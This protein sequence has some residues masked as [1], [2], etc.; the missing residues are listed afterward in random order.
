MN[1]KTRVAL[2]IIFLLTIVTDSF[3]QQIYQ[4][5][6]FDKMQG[7]P[8]Q[9]AT[10][11][12]I[13]KSNRKMLG[14]AHS[15]GMG[16]LQ[17][18]ADTLADSILVWVF[19]KKYVD[20]SS[21]IDYNKL[22]RYRDTIE[23]IPLSKVLQTVIVTGNKAIT[24]NG[25]TVSYVAD[26]FKLPAGSSAEDLLKKLPGIQVAKDGTIKAQGKKVEKVLVDGDDFFGEDA[27]VATKN[28]EASMIDK[29]EVIDAATRKS[30]ATGSDDEKMKI[31]NLKL[32]D[33]AKRG[34]FGK[35]EGG[36]S[37]TKRYNGTAMANVFH[38]NTKVAGFL[39]ADNMRSRM[40]WEDMRDLGIDNQSW[41]YDEDLDVWVNKGGDAS[42]GNTLEVIPN[43]L[44]TG[45]ILNQKF[46]DG[47][48]TLKMRY[49][50]N[51]SRYDGHQ[52]SKGT[53]FYGDK[54]QESENDN[55]INSQNL[56]NSGLL[57][58]DKT[59]D[60]QQKIHVGFTANISQYEGYN[61]T[62]QTILLDSVL[63]NRSQRTNPFDNKNEQYNVIGEY[64]KKF[65]KKGRFMGLKADYSASVLNGN[66]Y[67]Q[68]QGWLYNTIGD[69]TV[70]ALDQKTTTLNKN[71]NLKLSANF[72]EPIF[73]KG[74]YAEL[75]A[76]MA[77]ARN[78]S[79]YNTFAKNT[80]NNE[81]NLSLNSLSNNYYYNVNAFSEHI[82]LNF[83]SKKIEWYIGSK[84]HQVGMEQ[85]NIDTGKASIQ[86]NFNYFLPMA[87]FTWKYKRNS[88]LSLTFRKGVVAPTIQQI[89]PFVN[90][91]NPQ[92]ITTGNPSLTPIQNYNFSLKNNFWYAVSQTSLWANFSF[93]W[94]DNDI[95]DSTIIAENGVV[96]H[97]Y[98]HLGGNYN[99]NLNVWYGFHFKPWGIQ[100][101]PGFW[102]N[103]SKET[104][105]LNS[106]PVTTQTLNSGFYLQM[107][108][109]IDSLLQSSVEFNMNWNNASSDN[110]NFQNTNNLSWTIS[111]TQELQLPW[112]F[113]LIADVEYKILPTNRAF[114]D[115]QSFTLLNASIERFFL[116]ENRLSARLSLYD[117]LGQ[118][119]AI[120]RNV[121]G[122]TTNET[123]S[124]ALTRYVMLTLT[125]KF[126][127]KRKQA[128]NEGNF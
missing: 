58:I 128:E 76:S 64:E 107:S 24:M 14:Y 60:S 124:Q 125:Y 43:N 126:K 82:K 94:I 41:V 53:T 61:T 55:Y 4:S 114:A 117:I 63:V 122:N 123:I 113:K 111:T 110:P 78:T 49:T 27:S 87:N 112:K 71:N 1:Q 115:N 101:D 21:I 16:N 31:I 6:I 80:S 42:V 26:S 79:F 18:E 15:N 97:Y 109:S 106:K 105:Y 22:A 37:N 9:G 12:L 46:S 30:D 8:I 104:N 51:Q 28:L 52:Q 85:I 35:V 119:R 75:G 68:M 69:S 3:S 72:I 70:Q 127:N 44:K 29:V 62:E 39:S 91:S 90:N 25:D 121:W 17:I 54:N 59:I 13:Q 103:Y 57:S 74:F 86:R 34:Y 108:K 32:K 83:K 118:N 5:Y 23:L 120:R 33:A 98:T 45:G 99:A 77:N 36:Y 102:S 48:G 47:T 11:I 10:C 93:K 19:H 84:F 88:N 92:Y 73:I 81:Y 40:N 20:Y 50:H 56:K 65:T 66:R 38:T 2:L 89:Q 7:K 95:V 116:K 67:N 96:N 100:I